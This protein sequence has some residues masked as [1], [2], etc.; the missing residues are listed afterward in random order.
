MA[1]AKTLT[2]SRGH[3]YGRCMTIAFAST[4]ASKHGIGAR[5]AGGYKPYYPCLVGID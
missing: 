5:K 2:G 3:P 1:P 4:I